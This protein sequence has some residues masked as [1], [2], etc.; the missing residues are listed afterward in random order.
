MRHYSVLAGLG[1]FAAVGLVVAACGSNGSACGDCDDGIACTLDACNEADGTCQHAPIQDLCPQGQICDLAVGCKAAPPCSSDAECDDFDPCTDDTCD[2]IS[3]CRYT[4]NTAACND[5]NPCTEHDT[6]ADGV[7]A[8]TAAS[9]DDGNLCTTDS[10]VEGLGC[11][12]ADN[13]LDCDDDNACTTG[14]VCAQGVC[15]GVSITCDDD[16]LCTDDGCDPASGCTAT[17]NTAACDDGNACTVGEACADGACVGGT[18]T[19]VCAEDGDCI[20]FEDGDL[21]NG[22]LHCVNSACVLD[23]ATLISCDPSGDTA[24]QHN[25]CNPA[26]GSCAMQDVL[27]GS[28]CDDGDACTTGEVCG[29]GACAGGAEVCCGDSTDNDSDGL[30][31]CLDSDCVVDDLCGACTGTLAEVRAAALGQVSP[32]I[33]LDAVRVTSVRPITADAN[34]Y[35]IQKG[36]TGPAVFVFQD[37]EVPTVAVGNTL[38]LRVSNLVDYFGLLEVN[39]SVIE[40]NDGL[41]GSVADLV[42]DFTNGP[43]IGEG[44]ESELVRIDDAV[45][46]SG[47]GSAWMVAYADFAYQ[48][49]VYSNLWS[50]VQP[51]PGMRVGLQAPAGQFNANYQLTPH[52]PEDFLASDPAGC[53]LQVGDCRLQGPASISGDAGNPV[54]V[55][56]RVNVSG[57][58]DQSSGNDFWPS[59]LAQ[60]GVGPDGSSPADPGWTW[61]DAMPNPGWND[62]SDPGKDE[63]V[64]TLTLPAPAGSPYDYAYRFSGDH[65]A[66]WTYCDLDSSLND[67]DPAQAGDLQVIGDSPFHLFFSEYVEG[68]SYNK[69]FEVFNAGSDPVD[70][71]NCQIVFYSNGSPVP[72]TPIALVGTLAADDVFVICH[73]SADAAL[74]PLCDQL[75]GSLNFNGDDAVALACGGVV[76]D[77]IGQIGFDPGSSWQGASGATTQDH[78]LERMCNVTRGDALGTD[79]F[80]LDLEWLGLPIDTFSGLGSRG[81][82]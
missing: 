8:G 68:T 4:L 72:S 71:A 49:N 58:T 67:Y 20:G 13:A 79:V 18:N 16:N 65:G 34:G 7:C 77:V 69:A 6:C 64:G 41:A 25:T 53:T 28:S 78:T 11:Q 22:T 61:F 23:P 37:S 19:C 56:G 59:V 32:P 76:M 14:D 24:C 42:Q 51:C 9:C 75:T 80:D 52:R 60:V 70:L 63:Y 73:G 17:N 50:T 26:D 43:A 39:G 54:D 10:C 44:T 27:D 5:G 74:L 12:H 2:T 1:W 33:C 21:C 81:C 15:G 82:K 38:R 46:V 40:S 45:V 31:D 62:A 48:I 66:T 36:Q 57:L 30:T 55:Y 35:Y 47:N 29:A 3:G